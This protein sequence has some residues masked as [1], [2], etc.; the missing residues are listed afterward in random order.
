MFKDAY[1]RRRCILP[2]DGFFEWKAIK[3]QSA[4]Q[5]YAIAMKNGEPFGVGGLWENW[6][7]P[8]SGEWLRTFA[9]I[10]TDKS[11]AGGFNGPVHVC[12]IGFCDLH[13]NRASSRVIDGKGFAGGRFDQLAVD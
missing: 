13:Q 8:A 3:G 10:T 1:R 12:A 2:V 9:V 5:P 11:L 7:G 6:K 4:K